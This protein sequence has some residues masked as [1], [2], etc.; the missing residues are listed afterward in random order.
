MLYITSKGCKKSDLVED[1]P[2]AQQEHKPGNIGILRR[3]DFNTS[4]SKVVNLLLVTHGEKK[5]FT[6][7]KNMS[8]LLTKLNNQCKCKMHFCLN[9]LNGF[10]SPEARDKHYES[11]ID[12]E[13][14]RVEMPRKEEAQLK[15]HDGQKQL[16]VPFIMYADFESILE[17]F[18]S[19]SND[20]TKSGT[21]KMNIHTPSGW[22]TYSKFSYGEVPDPLEVYRGKDCAQKFIDHIV[23][24]TE[25]LYATFPEKAMTPL[26]EVQQREHDE[27][28]VC[29]ICLKA[30]DDPQNNRKVRDHCHYTGSYRGAAHNNCN[31]KYRIPS[32]IPI[33][34]HNL[35]GYD[36]HLFI[37]ELGKKFK[38]GKHWM[39]C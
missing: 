2:A 4:R 31:L 24:E 39:P 37:R 16:R 23:A 29:H 8:R 36:A 13:A 3:S 10:W 22:C 35:S 26:T 17:P 6:A 33:V 7:V 20:P 12:H 15:Y 5:H 19:V 34:F 32:H 14:V 27:A 21:E 28:I 9:C 38:D 30:F 1:C 18:D 25:R 11:C